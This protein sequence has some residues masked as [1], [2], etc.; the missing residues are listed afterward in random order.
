VERR[1]KVQVEMGAC[2]LKKEKKRTSFSGPGH[3]RGKKK[4]GRGFWQG[5]KVTLSRW[6]CMGNA[7]GGK[8]DF[9][10]NPLQVGKNDKKNKQKK[11]RDSRPQA[12][13]KWGPRKKTDIGETFL[14]QNNPCE[15]IKEKRA[16]L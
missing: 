1:S 13:T 11:K 15:R 4:V 2:G 12:E 5:A 8:R 16:G 10:F 6:E 3:P 9:H 7:G 14:T